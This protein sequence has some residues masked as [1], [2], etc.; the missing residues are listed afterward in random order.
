MGAPG[1]SACSS[2]ALTILRVG[3]EGDVDAGKDYFK[4]R[5]LRLSTKSN[6]IKE[7]EIYIQ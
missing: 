3:K 4:K 7:R 6:R 2:T 5:F 1:S